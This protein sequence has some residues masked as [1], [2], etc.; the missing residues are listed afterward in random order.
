MYVVLCKYIR[1]MICKSLLGCPISFPRVCDYPHT[2]VAN[3]FLWKRHLLLRGQLMGIS[4]V[5]PP[6]RF[7]GTKYQADAS[8]CWAVSVTHRSLN[9]WSLISLCSLL[10]IVWVFYLRIHGLIWGN[11]TCLSFES[12]IV[13]VLIC[14]VH[15]EWIFEPGLRYSLKLRFL[16]RPVEMHAQALFLWHPVVLLRILK[17][18]LLLLNWCTLEL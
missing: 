7:P 2:H 10:L 4:S 13:L 14:L 8:K 15:R 17:G 1:C 12:C 3:G 16:W 11:A 6:C 18:R 9:W 5:L